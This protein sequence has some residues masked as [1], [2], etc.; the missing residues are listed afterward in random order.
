MP[1][2]HPDRLAHWRAVIAQQQHSGLT[3]QAFCQRHRLT[4]SAF[5]RW[6]AR[7]QTL[8]QTPAPQHKPAPKPQPTTAF[9]PLRVLPDPQVEILLPSGLRLRLPL[10]ADPQQVARLIQAVQSC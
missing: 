9:V 4:P 1:N 8:E 5:F 7:L 2:Y 3:V 6:K 10:N